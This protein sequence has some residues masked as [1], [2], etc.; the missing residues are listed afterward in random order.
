MRKYFWIGFVLVLASANLSFSTLPSV[1]HPDSPPIVRISNGALR[2]VRLSAS[3]SQVAFLGVPYAAPPVGELRWKPPQSAKNWDGTRDATVFGPVCPQFPQPWLPYVEGQE[4]CLYLNLWTAQL[5]PHAN[6]PVIVFFHGGSNTAGYSQSTPLGLSLSRLGVIVVTANYRLGPFGFL[7]HPALSAESEHQSSGNYGLL[8]QIQALRWVRENVSRFGGDP[9]RVTVMGQSS[10][11]VD[12]CLLMASPLARDLFRAA[13]LQ[14]GECQSTLNE[15]IRKPVHYNFVEDTGEAVGQRLA[16]DLG[17]ADGTGALQ[18][19]RNIPANVILKTW[20]QDAGVHFDAIVDGWVV[21]AQPA[22]IFADGKQLLIPTLIG[23]DA[24]EASVF[25]DGGIHTVDQY[26]RYLQQYT[27]KFPDQEF[28]AYRANSDTDVAARYLQ[29]QDDSFA[30]G[31]YSMALAMT[32]AGQHAYLYE[33]TFAEAGKRARLGAHHG[34]ELNFLSDSYPQDWQHDP[35]DK[36]LGETIRNC[37][38]QFAKTGDPSYP[39]GPTWPAFD[40]HLDQLLELGRDVR[41]RP[42]EP[43]LHVMQRL[44]LQAIADSSDATP[45]AK[46]N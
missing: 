46:S 21:P 40:P 26:K 18:K 38:A 11:A 32:R 14:S 10:G 28:A 8:D 37:W 39:G 2:G 30:Y 24:D 9:G 42:I 34:L 3:L 17:I 41:L 5:S 25:G 19:L 15:D 7:A 20:K 35:E 6:L 44:M 22:V 29:L 1:L 27:G 23:S 12:I 13:I 36:V 31:A 16:K 4:D 43:R 45:C 33:F